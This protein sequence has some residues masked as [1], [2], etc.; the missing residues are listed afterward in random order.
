M[1]LLKMC[2]QENTFAGN[3]QDTGPSCHELGVT[4][5]QTGLSLANNNTVIICKNEGI[6]CAQKAVGENVANSIWTPM[7]TVRKKA[8]ELP[9]K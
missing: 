1:F 3:Q 9:P 5:L 8:K 4:E 6:F 2:S 7:N